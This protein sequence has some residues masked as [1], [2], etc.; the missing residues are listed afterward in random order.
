MGEGGKGGRMAIDTNGKRVTLSVD[1]LKKA[2]EQNQ[3]EKDSGANLNAAAR[4][5]QDG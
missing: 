1:G 5:E 2:R 3:Q 4:V